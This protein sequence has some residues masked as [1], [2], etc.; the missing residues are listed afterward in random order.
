[1]SNFESDRDSWNYEAAVAEVEAIVEQIESGALPLDEVF[2]QFEVAIARLRACES[3]L[4][5]GK[6]QMGLL[7]ETLADD[8][9]SPNSEEEF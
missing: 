9:G 5:R 6:E 7:V 1:M 3:F 2:A 8:T 4:A